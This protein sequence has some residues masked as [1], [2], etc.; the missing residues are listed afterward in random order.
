MDFIYKN[1]WTIWIHGPLVVSWESSLVFTTAILKKWQFPKMNTGGHKAVLLYDTF[2]SMNP[3]ERHLKLSAWL[4]TVEF[5][6][7]NT[8][9]SLRSFTVSSHVLDS[10]SHHEVFAHETVSFFTTVSSASVFCCL[11][12]LGLNED[13]YRENHKDLCASCLL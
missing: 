3:T 13:C 12:G 11:A 1:Y 4:P 7:F 9:S 8:F 2:S 5:R 6:G 10:V